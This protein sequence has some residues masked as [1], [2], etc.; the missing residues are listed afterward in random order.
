LDGGRALK[1]GYKRWRV[2]VRVTA[3]V[4]ALPLSTTSDS[5][6]NDLT[7]ILGLSVAHAVNMA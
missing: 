2:R 6:K 4:P 3:A 1:V 5:R 7:E